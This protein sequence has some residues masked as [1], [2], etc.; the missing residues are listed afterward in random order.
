MLSYE[1]VPEAS[2]PI[3]ESDMGKACYG[4]PG[5][6]SI[7]KIPHRLPPEMVARERADAERKWET[8]QQIER[9]ASAIAISALEAGTMTDEIIAEI[10]AAA[11]RAVRS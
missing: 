1:E 8:R 7:G 2:G 6:P 11:D 10:N 9:L 4:Q 5:Y 3:S